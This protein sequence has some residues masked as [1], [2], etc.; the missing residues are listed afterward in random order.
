MFRRSLTTP[1]SWRR[2]NERVRGGW[3]SRLQTWQRIALGALI[4]VAY[5]AFVATAGL[6]ATLILTGPFLLFFIFELCR[7]VI[8]AVRRRAGGIRGQV[9]Q[10]PCGPA[11]AQTT[12]RPILKD[13]KW[14]LWHGA[15]WISWSATVVRRSGKTLREAYALA[16]EDLDN[17]QKRA[18][19]WA[20]HSGHA[21]LVRREQGVDVLIFGRLLMVLTVK[22]PRIPQ[23]P[24]EGAAVI[25]LKEAFKIAAED[26]KAKVSSPAS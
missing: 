24:D 26:A 19:G 6:V 14:C 13:G 5:F 9:G 16:V 17:D 10:D 7:A 12:S 22:W 21:R 20:H 4:W 18:F 23:H 25:D 8:S 2:L 1:A 11:P 15:E 3:W